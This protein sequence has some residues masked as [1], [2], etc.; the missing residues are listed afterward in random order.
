MDATVSAA[1]RLVRG[2]SQD[3]RGRPER[4]DGDK[5]GRLGNTRSHPVKPVDAIEIRRTDAPRHA[6]VLGTSA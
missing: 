3:V 2:A 6:D 1:A 4:C 5:T